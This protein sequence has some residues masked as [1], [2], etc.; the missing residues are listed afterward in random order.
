LTAELSPPLSHEGGLGAG[1]EW[2]ARWMA[3]KHGLAVELA[4][5]D[6][7][8]PL[9]ED[10]KVLLFES[11]RELLFNAVKHARARA[12][13]V[14]LRR[15]DGEMLQ[16]TVRDSGPGFDPAVLQ[17]IGGIEGGF[18]LF[19]IRERL[20]LIGGRVEID[21]SPGR[22]S[23]V[24][25]VAPL[26]AVAAPQG[27]REG[28]GQVRDPGSPP[29]GRDVPVGPPGPDARIR[30]LLADDHAVVREG[31]AR[32]LGGEPD[33]EV[34]GQAPDGREAVRLAHELRPDV[35]LMDMSMRGLDGV[36]ATRAIHEDLPDVRIIGLSM[37]EE[38][39][40]GR[41]MREAGAVDYLT[42]SG[43]ADELIAAIRRS[44]K[45]RADL[46]T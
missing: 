4:V 21:S 12:V 8:P 28:E 25:L 18:G 36:G 2:L 44:A 37:F 1:L 43:P 14:S 39:E 29:A 35:V 23:R 3:D 6:P 5:N 10:V 7:L 33:M 45:G 24:S 42:K 22:G 32:L 34:V 46:L 31:L 9:L 27:P 17:Q 38:A 40:R 13:G 20:G 11:V 16:I 30:V 15:V 26:S 19:S 41:A